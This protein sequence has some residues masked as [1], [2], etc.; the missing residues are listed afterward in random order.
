MRSRENMWSP[1]MR[2]NSPLCLDG[3]NAPM[4][5]GGRGGEKKND[6]RDPIRHSFAVAF[7]CACGSI[8]MS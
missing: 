1:G 3:P 5:G 6:S 4:G 7:W 2:W 8:Q